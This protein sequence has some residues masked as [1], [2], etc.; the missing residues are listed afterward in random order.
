MKIINE[1]DQQASDFL[2]KSKVKI[3]KEYVRHGKHFVDDTATR[4]I[5]EI[6]IRRK[7]K[8]SSF[9]FGQSVMN[10][11]KKIKPTDYDVLSC[12]TKYDPGTLEDFCS[13][14][15]Y[16]TDSIRAGKTYKGVCKEWLMVSNFFTEAEIEELREI[17]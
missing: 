10:S 5:Y 9:M 8:E 2:K 13:E 14:F 16:D 15:G 3:I 11:S 4:D 12:L 7:D 1:Y 17:N 6:T